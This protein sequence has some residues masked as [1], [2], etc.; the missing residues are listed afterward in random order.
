MRIF[1]ESVLLPYPLS[2]HSSPHQPFRVDFDAHMLS[3]LVFEDLPFLF[4]ISSFVLSYSP[5]DSVRGKIMLPVKSFLVF[6]FLTLTFVESQGRR[7]KG[8]IRTGH[9]KD[10]NREGKC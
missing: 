5:L 4:Y 2:A 3:S 8:H 6:L 10:P 9:Y 7:G 1:F